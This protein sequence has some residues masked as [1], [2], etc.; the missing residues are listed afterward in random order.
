MYMHVMY[1]YIPQ[2]YWKFGIKL[3]D[4]LVKVILVD[5]VH[6][7]RKLRDRL[8]QLDSEN[9]ALTKAQLET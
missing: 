8:A 9:T 3:G 7:C 6:Y 1:M 5:F 2:L 4:I